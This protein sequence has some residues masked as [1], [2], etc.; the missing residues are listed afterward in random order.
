MPN[1]TVSLRWKI[2]FLAALSIVAAGLASATGGYFVNRALVEQRMNSVR[3][4]ADSGVSIA[5]AYYDLAQKGTISEADAKERASTAI[6]AIRYNG[7]EYLW[8][9]TSQVVAVMHGNR[10]LIGKSGSEIRDRNGVYVIREAV[11]GGMLPVPE[12]VRYEWPRPGD[13]QGPTFEKI[14]YSGYF[15]P[16]DWVIG[17][18]VYSDDLK[19]AFISMMETFGLVVS[20]VASIALLVGWAI[21]RSIIKPLGAVTEAVGRLAKGDTTL[22][23]PGLQR[24]DE[25]GAIS[26]ALDVFRQHM[27]KESELAAEQVEA[28]QR[29]DREK[30]AALASMAEQIE[31]ETGAALE[32]IHQRTS[33]MT[34][35]ADAMGASAGRTGNAAETAAGAAAQALTNAQTVA[36]AAE[37]LISSIHEISRQASQST[38]VVARAVTAG[39]ETRA[40]IETLNEQVA[41]IGLVADMI[42]AIAAKT[43]LLALNAT[44]EA[45]R[46]GDAGKGFAVVASEVKGLATQTASSTQE[47]ARHIHEVRAATAASVAAVAQIEATIGEIDAISG[48]IAAA[49]EQQGAATA[50]IARNVAETA[51]AANVMTSRTTEVST[52][53]G[54]TGRRATEVYAD[55]SALNDAVETL[56]Q[57]VIQLVR[58]STAAADH[59]ARAMSR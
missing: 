23:L 46:A 35:T 2:G 27:V 25:I 9:W 10:A 33:A 59:T 47:I 4:I 56:R 58:S 6:G 54:E 16:W 41:R 1:L 42:G 18:G 28:H 43:N 52:E 5:R 3:F 31:S 22:T 11:R 39:N 57:S 13:P 34:A 40:T 48:S 12:F 26:R 51:A 44:I 32:Q 49:V 50:E 14:A 30:R 45:A 15:Q 37:Q 24:A 8:I 29:A 19:S 21:A 17:T 53:A 36:S 7:A 38:S 55:A 20:G